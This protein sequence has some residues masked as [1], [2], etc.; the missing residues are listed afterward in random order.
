MRTS[1]DVVVS[2]IGRELYEKFYRGYTRKK[3][4]LDPSEL[5]SILINGVWAT[6]NFVTLIAAAIG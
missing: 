5:D 2:K 3:W 1:E 6:A 4:G